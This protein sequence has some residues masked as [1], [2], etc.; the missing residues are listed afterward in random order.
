MIPVRT[1]LL[2]FLLAAPLLAGDP[3]VFS[4]FRGNGEDG[5]H[6]ATSADGLQW[7]VLNEG[8]SLLQ[9]LVGESKPMRDPSI[10]RGPD[11]SSTWFGRRRGKAGVS[12]MHHRK[13]F[14]IG[15]SKG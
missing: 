12:D 9:P 11:G 8:R 4:Y 7:R 1:S 2:L 14:R 3:L 13:I 6:L 5:L 10:V 15:R